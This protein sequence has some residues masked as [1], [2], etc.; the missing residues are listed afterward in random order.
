M[1]KFSLVTILIISPMFAEK[2]EHSEKSLIETSFIFD[3]GYTI[4]SINDTKFS[5]LYLDGIEHAH[6]VED[7]TKHDH[8][9]SIR[10]RGFNL[11]YAEFGI[12]SDVDPYWSLNSIFHLSENSFEIEEVYVQSL[13]FPTGLQLKL[14][15]FYSNF[16]RLNSQHSHEWQFIDAPL[17]YSAMFGDHNLLEKGVSL[18]YVLPTAFYSLLS[19]EILEGANEQTFVKDELVYGSNILAE[20][21][22]KPAFMIS[23]KTSIEFGK[24]ILLGGISYLEG[25]S[26]LNHFEH[27]KPHAL[28][29]IAKITG[30]DLT[31][32]Y[33]LSSYSQIIW[34]N[35][36]IK[37]SQDGDQLSA[38]NRIQASDGNFTTKSAELNLGGFY[39]QLFYKMNSNF[40]FGIRYSV[41]DENSKKIGG[42]EK[43]V[44]EN[45]NILSAVAQY[46]TSEFSSFKVQYNSN[47]SK[48]IVSTSQ[49]E[50]FSEV[51]FSYNFAIG[52]HP[53]HEF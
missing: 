23:A 53:A 17:I 2:Y 38:L 39:S 18:S 28:D 3:A 43:T 15:K 1:K 30:F 11:N 45:Q 42:V 21:S 26:R 27:E 51:I 48:N 34:Q 10:N 31:M 41:L 46:S 5:S 14:G 20:K 49:P 40:G 12:S 7:E 33:E 44:R 29:G 4:R 50:N 37:R 36:L 35:E 6:S 25:I 9:H 52:A 47:R 8:K 24:A 16:G 22:D 32:K 13:R 19:F